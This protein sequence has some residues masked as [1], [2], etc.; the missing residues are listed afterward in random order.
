MYRMKDYQYFELAQKQIEQYIIQPGD[1]LNLMIYSRDGFKLVDVLGSPGSASGQ[2]TSSYAVDKEGFAKFPV[3][4]DFYVKGYTES[5]LERL[6]AEKFAGLFVD[7]YVILKV[8]NRR[9]IV[10]SGSSASVIS[11]NRTPTSLLEV[12]SAAGGLGN[13]LKAYKIKIIRGDLKNPEVHLVDLSTLEGVR[14]T[15]LI[16]QGNDIIYIEQRRIIANDILNTFMPYISFVTTI[17][18]IVLLATTLGKQ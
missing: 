12:L 3:L 7:P 14:K 5:E 18:S 8:I 11:L 4:G 13:D 1:E 15:D 9:A 6:L 17:S 2:S 10:F 16:V